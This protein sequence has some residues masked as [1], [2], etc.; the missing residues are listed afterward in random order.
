MN[1]VASFEIPLALLTA[2]GNI[3]FVN[4]LNHLVHKKCYT[5]TKRVHEYSESFDIDFKFI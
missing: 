4:N 1:V 5:V 3:S 2:S